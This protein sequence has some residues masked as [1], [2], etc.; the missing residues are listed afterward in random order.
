MLNPFNNS[1]YIYATVA[2]FLIS[3]HLTRRIMCKRMDVTIK[4]TKIGRFFL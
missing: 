2:L 3:K 1:Q 4:L